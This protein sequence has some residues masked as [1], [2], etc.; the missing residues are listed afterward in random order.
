MKLPDIN[1]KTPF[2]IFL[3][4][5]FILAVMCIIIGGLVFLVIVISKNFINPKIDTTSLTNIGFA[6]AVSMSAVCFSWYRT[7]ESNETESLKLIKSSGERFLFAGIIFIC[8]SAIKYISINE[9][10]FQNSISFFIYLFY[11]INII[12]AFF[13]SISVFIFIDTILDVFKYLFKRYNKIIR[14]T[15]EHII[16]ENKV[17]DEEVKH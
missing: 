16:H 10:I 11:T 15:T 2:Q 12:Y 1:I 14:I 7:L 13:F 4:V 9:T 8:A 5:C 6:F 17:N 3:M